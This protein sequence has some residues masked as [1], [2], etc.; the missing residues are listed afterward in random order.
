[1][2]RA[3]S[4]R[5]TRRICGAGPVA[6]GMPTVICSR[7]TWGKSAIHF[8]RNNDCI[9]KNLDANVQNSLHSDNLPLRTIRKFARKTRDYLRAYADPSGRTET[10]GDVEKL[11]GTFKCHRGSLDFDFKFI[12]DA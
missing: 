8:R 7:N 4:R 10:H 9:A 11:R 2:R 3:A 5:N 6:K 1:M 12:R